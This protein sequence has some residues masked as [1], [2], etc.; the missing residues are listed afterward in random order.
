MTEKS[1]L[2]DAHERKA[3]LLITVCLAIVAYLLSIEWTLGWVA[4]I[5]AVGVPLISAM[6]GMLVLDIMAFG[7]QGLHPDKIK[8]VP[9]FDGKTDTLR[10]HVLQE[11][12]NKIEKNQKILKCEANFLNCAKWCLYAAAGVFLAVMLSSGHSPD[13]AQIC[14]PCGAIDYQPL[15]P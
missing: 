11:Y 10:K 1:A 12:D 3:V 2:Q 6:S 13:G 15:L 4:K 5:V 9:S 7:Q 14:A 8:A